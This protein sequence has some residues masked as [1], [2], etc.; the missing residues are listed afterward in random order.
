DPHMLLYTVSLCVLTGLV[1]GLVPALES[2]RID[3]N[4]G[5]RD[6]FLL[7]GRRSRTWL[8]GTLV[9]AQVAVCLVVLIAA[10]LLVRGLN[11]AQHIEPGF[12]TH[13]I[14][15]A[16]FDLRREG[17]DEARVAAF[18]AQLLERTSAFAGDANVSL[19]AMPPLAG[20]G[21]GENVTLEGTTSPALSM[22]DAGSHSYFNLLGLPLVAG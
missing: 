10:G 9:G 3:L 17:Y 14:L 11:A 13:S 5:L 15:S 21:W 22:L 8:R 1:F 12:N 19:S 18:K 4:S 7:A 6:E 20:M 16:N 2:T